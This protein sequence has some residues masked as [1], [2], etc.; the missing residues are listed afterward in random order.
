MSGSRATAQLPKSAPNYQT[1]LSA[2][3]QTA[4][5]DEP[6]KDGGGDTG[7]RPFELVMSGLSA[8][9]AITLRMYAQRKGWPLEDVEVSCEL[10]KQG[11]VST[12]A[13]SVKVTGALAEEQR[14][15]LADI[16][17]R[18]PVTLLLKAGAT[19]ETKLSAG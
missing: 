9:T 3:D 12:I 4:K 17:E 6:V 2:R 16:C 13:R 10:H 18:T 19:I 7:F 14:A 1:L 15:R 8:C 11:D 5:A